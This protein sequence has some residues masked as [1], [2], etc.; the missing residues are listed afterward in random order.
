MYLEDFAFDLLVNK[1]GF[2]SWFFFFF[3]TSVLHKQ[4]QKKIIIKNYFWMCLETFP[5][6]YIMHKVTV[7][8]YLCIVNRVN[9]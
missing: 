9:L 1:L 8:H 4:K 5:D 6:T 7:I 3:L 2:K